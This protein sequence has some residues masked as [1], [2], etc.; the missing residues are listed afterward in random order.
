MKLEGA[1]VVVFGRSYHKQ[2]FRD[3]LLLKT[4][5]PPSPA[6]RGPTH[7]GGQVTHISPEYGQIS[8]GGAKE[9]LIRDQFCCLLV[10]IC[11]FMMIGLGFPSLLSLGHIH[12]T[13]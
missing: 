2:L 11:V 6:K 12:R 10:Y 3:T 7:T 13:K 5:L 1:N 8:T 4:S 9:E